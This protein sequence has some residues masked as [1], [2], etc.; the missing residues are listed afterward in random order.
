M[1]TSL[2]NRIF[3][4]TGASIV[5]GVLG[6]MSG[7]VTLFVDIN[8]T[9]SIQWLLFVIL[10]MTSLIIIL[11]KAHFDIAKIQ[12]QPQNYEIPI[13]YFE[14]E[15]LFI[16]KKNESFVN[17]IIVGCYLKQDDIERLAYVGVIHLVQEKV[18]QIKIRADLRVCDKIPHNS[19]ALKE[20]VVRPVVP[21]TALEH[22][23]SLE[24]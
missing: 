15:N 13:R 21:V 14:D 3:S 8:Q 2:L 17:N 6:F 18:I 16:I 24:K 11:L 7:L 20:I 1:N 9:V 10:L 12:V 22:F 23:N 19:E 5:I 4:F